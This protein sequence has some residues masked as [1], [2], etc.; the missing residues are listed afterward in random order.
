M[1]SSELTPLVESALPSNDP[2]QAALDLPCRLSVELE[3]PRFTVGDLLA[4][5]LNS[6]MD[7]RRK[8]GSHVPVM[9]NGEMIGW[10]EFD[11]VDDRLAMRLTELV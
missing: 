8:D 10:A 1:E 3:V 2:W 4:L 5:D 9:V 7:T 6:V 11:V